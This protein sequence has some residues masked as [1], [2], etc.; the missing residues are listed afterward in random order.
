[1]LRALFGRGEIARTTSP[2]GSPERR[3][4]SDGDVASLTQR[5]AADLRDAIA[6]IEARDHLSAPWLDVAARVRKVA[7]I[8]EA[9]RRVVAARLSAQEPASAASPGAVTAGIAHGSSSLWDGEE[10]ALRFLLEMGKLNVLVRVATLHVATAAAGAGASG[11]GE[12]DAAGDLALSRFDKSLAV[13]FRAA[14]SHR[15]AVQTVNLSHVCELVATATVAAVRSSLAR[16]AAPHPRV[17]LA[18]LALALWASFGSAEFL[19]AIGEDRAAVELLKTPLSAPLAAVALVPALALF[20]LND[21]GASGDLEGWPQ[22]RLSGAPAGAAGA[23][24]SPQRAAARAAADALT[25]DALTGVARVVAAE[26]F[27]SA[28]PR[29]LAGADAALAAALGGCNAT[30]AASCAQLRTALQTRY[31]GN[32]EARQRLRPLN[33]LLEW[34]G[35]KASLY[36]E[37]R[38]AASEGKS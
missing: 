35:R 18:G 24:E 5:L 31:A 26:D 20:A 33:D 11:A 32:L 30:F 21:G 2:P 34:V 25:L 3:A 14:W 15:V 7:S 22:E 19:A 37:A 23:E 17:T 38:A 29:L 12:G 10:Q 27:R 8:V 36:E 1:M 6:G 13:L 16:G 28:R 9:E 4:P